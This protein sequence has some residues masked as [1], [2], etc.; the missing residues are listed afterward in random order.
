MEWDLLGEDYYE[1]IVF[2]EKLRLDREIFF[3]LCLGV[4]NV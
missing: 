1:G 2:I 3:I 4:E